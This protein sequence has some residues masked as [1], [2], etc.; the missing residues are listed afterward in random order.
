MIQNQYEQ[1]SSY[2]KELEDQLNI[3]YK[4]LLFNVRVASDISS[5]FTSMRIIRVDGTVVISRDKL[6]QLCGDIRRFKSYL[7]NRE[8]EH[9]FYFKHLVKSYNELH[10]ILENAI[11]KFN[12]SE[13]SDSQFTS[14]EDLMRVDFVFQHLKYLITSFEDYILGGSLILDLNFMLFGENI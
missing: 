4:K 7:S 9:M 13:F 1:F 8:S 14:L 5:F 11:S 2:R 3:K 12:L 10:P 6:D